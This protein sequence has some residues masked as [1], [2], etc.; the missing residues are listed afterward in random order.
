MD[1]ILTFHSI[2]YNKKPGKVSVVKV[3]KDPSVQ[4]DD[5]Y[6]SG[7]IHT[8]PGEPAN[9][10]SKS[11]PKGKSSALRP[12]S[13]GKLVRWNGP[14]GYPLT[15]TRRERNQP[16]Y[17]ERARLRGKSSSQTASLPKVVSQTPTYQPQPVPEHHTTSRS[18]VVPRPQPVPEPVATVNGNSYKRTEF[19]QRVQPPPPPPPMPPQPTAA[20]NV[21]KALYD[22]N[23]ATL[24]PTTL[25]KD[26]KLEVVQKDDKGK[27]FYV[28]WHDFELAN[29]LSVGWWLVK[30]SDGSP[31]GWVPSAYLEEVAPE[32]VPLRA[33]PIPVPRA[34]PPPPPPSSSNTNGIN[35]ANV[36][37]HALPVKAK[38]TPPEPPKRP[39]VKGRKPPPPPNPRDSAV[40]MGTSSGGSGRAT[41]DSTSDSAKGPSLAA[42]IASMI[43]ARNSSMQGKKN[44]DDDW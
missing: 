32:P 40:S 17:W 7:T 35:G 22:F 42:D 5:F 4:R 43:R 12:I 24:S 16:G 3:I 21:F 19:T 20:N 8:G 1:I 34:V 30:K 2:E 33:P 23:D 31:N 39:L 18:R 36:T 11:V 41:P 9:S 10:R 6:K 29:E 44:D 28:E 14:A 38:P 15:A 37:A 26:E 13:K 27:P 25:Q